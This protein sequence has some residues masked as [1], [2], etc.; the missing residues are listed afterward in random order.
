MLPIGQSPFSL[1]ITL[2]KFL[3][4]E[5]HLRP[6]PQASIPFHIDTMLRRCDAYE[7]DSDTRYGGIHST[8]LVNSLDFCFGVKKKKRLDVEYHRKLHR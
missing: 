3:R 5:M 7:A 8:T 1:L 4:E 2:V 6:P